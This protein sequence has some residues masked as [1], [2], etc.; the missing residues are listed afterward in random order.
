MPTSMAADTLRLTSV[1]P[2]APHRRA[3]LDE[4]YRAFM[5]KF[6]PSANAGVAADERRDRG[7]QR[8]PVGLNPEHQSPSR[9][10]RPP[11]ARSAASSPIAPAVPPPACRPRGRSDRRAPR[12]TAPAPSRRARRRRRRR[13]SR[14]SAPSCRARPR[15]RRPPRGAAARRRRQRS[16]RPSTRRPAPPGAR[17]GGAAAIAAATSAIAWPRPPG[18]GERP[19][20]RRSNSSARTPWRER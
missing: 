1:P 9:A 6:S 11:A 2:D 13:R 14:A 12:R 7:R 3:A 4:R 8:R 20:Q 17:R 19:K 15:G 10:R 18:Q 16:R 5:D